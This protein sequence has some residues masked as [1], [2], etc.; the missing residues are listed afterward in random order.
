[1]RL[2]LS[3]PTLLTGSLW[4][5]TVAAAYWAGTAGGKRETV[6]PAAGL[7]PVQTLAGLMVPGSPRTAEQALASERQRASDDGAPDDEGDL[8]KDLTSD[9]CR[10]RFAS[11]ALMPPGRER[12]MEYYRLISQWARIDGEAALGAAAGIDEPKLR[13]ELRESALRNWARGNPEAAY[14]FA[15]RN[16]NKDLPDN[17]M[18]LVFDGLGRSHPEKALAFFDA[19]RADLEKQGDRASMVF[20]ELYERGGHDQLVAWAERQPAG[21]MRDMALNRIIDRW[22]RYDPAAARDWM[23]RSV[24][25][26]ENLGP[27]RVELAESWARVNPSDAL[28][29]VSS[30]PKDQQDKEYYSRIYGR[31]IQ[32]DRNAAAQYLA[33]QPPGP[34][35]DRPIE[36][37]TYEVMGQN[38]AD[39][40][41]WAESIN[42][43]GRRWRAIERVADQWRRKDPD[44]LQKYVQSG[45]FTDEQKQKLLRIEKK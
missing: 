33:S 22:A 34:H 27:A 25:N 21:K 11:I 41:P 31:W 42:D 17:R 5:A 9:D 6:R 28:N 30:L 39:T 23:D 3:R 4:L 29:W 10:R 36:R 20:D 16:P 26:K 35:L 12:N 43:E 13:Y 32:Y 45:G 15:R 1:M 37:Y 7:P 18:E 19:H 44:A 14:D 40:M 8:P 38:P 2:P 24:T